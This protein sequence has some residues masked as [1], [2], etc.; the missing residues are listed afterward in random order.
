M[1]TFQGS[2][3]LYHYLHYGSPIQ[4]RWGGW[5][6]SSH[7]L[8]NEGWKFHATEER[9]LYSDRHMAHLVIT[10]PDKY[11]CMSGRI[12]MS[13]QDFLKEGYRQFDSPLAVPIQMESFEAKSV[14]KCINAD[15]MRNWKALTEIDIMAPTS[16]RHS[17]IRLKDL[18]IFKQVVEE[19]KTQ[20]FIPEKSVDQ[21]FNEILK[22]QFPEQKRLILPDSKPILKAQILTMVA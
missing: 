9:D 20:F 5:V 16:V 1:S 10:S 14:F 18:R 21:L 17:K 22:I 4:F 7:I 8:R 11:M 19:P 3:N 13:Y 6:S 2:N 15:E 12:Y